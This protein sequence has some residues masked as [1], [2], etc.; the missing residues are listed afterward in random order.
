ML[1]LLTDRLEVKHISCFVLSLV[2]CVI[3][4]LSFPHFF[5]EVYFPLMALKSDI[6]CVK[7]YFLKVNFLSRY[8]NQEIESLET[9]LII[10]LTLYEKKNVIRSTLASPQDINLTQPIPNFKKKISFKSSNIFF[11]LVI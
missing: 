5:F 6:K 4:Y 3:S 11:A 2:V 9:A 7:T 1:L 8:S 10:F